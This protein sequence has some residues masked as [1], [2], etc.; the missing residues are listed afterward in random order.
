MGKD[1]MRAEIWHRSTCSNSR[2]A[3]EILREAGIEPVIVDYVAN[4]PDK[5]RLRQAIADAGLGVRQA[6]RSQEP[7]YAERGLADP[8]LS[9]DALLDAMLACPKLINRP[10]VFTD[11]GVRL[12]RPPERVRELLG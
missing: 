12:C 7:E 2:G 9:D 4:P 10:F 6:I 1:A 8:A 11:K 3:L 5:A